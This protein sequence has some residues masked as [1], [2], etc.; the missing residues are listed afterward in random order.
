MKIHMARHGQSQWQVAPSDN[1]DTPLSQAG[2]R[3]AR[4]LA[5]WLA[6]HPALDAK[7]RLDV[8]SVVTSP[9]ERARQTAACVSEAL[10]LPADVQPS[11]AEAPF[12]VVDELPVTEGPLVAGPQPV[13]DL[14]VRYAGFRAQAWTALAELVRQAETTGGPVL[15]VT[16]GGL[17]KTVLRVAMKTD[18][19]CFQVYNATITS[20]EWK[21]GRWRVVHL[22]LWDHLPAP[23]RTL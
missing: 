23:L 7:G 16:H 22:S 12:H 9:L 18:L 6:A 19:T 5:G 2:Q 21:K 17:I 10:G 20:L 15:A 8:A 11:L 4:L 14:S 13:R 1:L 3:Q